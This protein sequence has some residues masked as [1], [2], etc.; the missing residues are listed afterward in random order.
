MTEYAVFICVIKALGQEYNRFFAMRENYINN[1]KLSGEEV[2]ESD[3]PNGFIFKIAVC[4]KHGRNLC[5]III[6]V[7][8]IF[9]CKKRIVFFIYI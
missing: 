1:I 2:I 9:L 5:Q 7:A 6:A 8:K 3:K 4:I